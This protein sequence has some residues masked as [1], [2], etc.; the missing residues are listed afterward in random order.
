MAVA[1]GSPIIAADGLRM[2]NRA[3]GRGN[4]TTTKTGI[5]TTSPILRVDNQALKAGGLYVILASGMRGDSS[6]NTDIE[7][8]S[9]RYSSSGAA[10]TASTLLVK[11]E[12][13]DPYTGLLIGVLPVAAD[14]TYSFLLCHER[15]GAGTVQLFAEG[16][17]INMVII[18]L[19][20]DPG[21]TGVDL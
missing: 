6:T 13:G 16:N 1:S 18:D 14:A 9:I 12:F 2:L 20:A 7:I 21:D 19:A 3:T 8:P 4:R 11:G 17:G 15:F 10:T 5:T